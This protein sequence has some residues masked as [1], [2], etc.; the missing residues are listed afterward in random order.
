MKVMKEYTQDNIISSELYLLVVKPSEL[1]RIF[2]FIYEI[3][4]HS[5]KY[6]LDSVILLCEYNVHRI[7]PYLL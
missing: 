5:F 2:M 6:Y 3:I 7:I 4:N 1:H